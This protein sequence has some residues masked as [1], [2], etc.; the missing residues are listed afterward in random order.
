MRISEAYFEQLTDAQ[1]KALLFDESNEVLRHA[2]YA[3]LL[4]T[5]PTYACVRA[6]IAASYYL[7]GGTARIVASGAA[8]SDPTQTECA[9]MRQRLLTLGVPADAVVDEPHARDTVGNMI[10]SLGAIYARGN[11]TDVKSVAVIT[12]PFHM[13]RS[14]AL[15]KLFLPHYIQVFGY[16]EHTAEQCLGWRTDARL[17]RSVRNEIALLRSLAQQHLIDDMEI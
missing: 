5:E 9:V 1:I 16:T 14:L 4:G 7:R 2:D 13:R 11:V 10:C 3:F 17:E 8:V 6:E 12:E 15:A